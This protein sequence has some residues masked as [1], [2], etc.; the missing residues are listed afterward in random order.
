MKPFEIYNQEHHVLNINL[1]QP[2]TSEEKANVYNGSIPEPA[3]QY[4]GTP[5]ST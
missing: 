5:M 3:I 4:W 1:K 2:S